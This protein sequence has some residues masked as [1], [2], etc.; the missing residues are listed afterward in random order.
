MRVGEELETSAFVRRPQLNA[1]SLGATDRGDMTAQIHEKL[2]LDGEETS[3]AFCPSLPEGHPRVF[4]PGPDEVVR[5]AADVVLFSTACW[6]GYQGT[7]EIK[8]G[9]FYLI[10]LRGRF[11]LRPGSPVLADWFSGVLRVPRGEK[12][13]H[14]HMG[15]GSIYEQ[16]LHV[17]IENG[18]VVT[19]R[20]VDSRAKK[21]DVR[22]IGWKNLPGGEN[23]FPGD[24]EL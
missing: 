6:R 3:M 24:D 15:F 12:L 22:E 13:L 23:R 20:V 19:T 16:E 11:Q 4:E 17:K 9:R 8:D 1:R 14:V 2:I 10:A 5:D 18:K 7:W 21:H